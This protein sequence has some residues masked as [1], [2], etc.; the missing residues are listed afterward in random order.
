M[1]DFLI[2]TRK[3]FQ[4][5]DR[6]LTE[7]HGTAALERWGVTRAVVEAWHKDALERISRGELRVPLETIES[8]R[9][10]LLARVKSSSD[11]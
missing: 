7:T 4:D 2:D 6:R 1:I 10:S 3:H 8:T 9:Q 5:V 11:S